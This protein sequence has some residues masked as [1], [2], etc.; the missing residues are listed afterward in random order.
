MNPQPIKGKLPILISLLILVL[1]GMWLLSRCSHTNERS[2]AN[3]FTRPTGDTIAVAI[4]MSPTSYFFS[5]DTAVGFD[6]EMLNAIA[7]AH[8]LNLIFQPFV[9]VDY[10]LDG[11]K[12]G[13]FDV[14]VATLPASSSMQND[15]LSTDEV[16]VDRQVLVKLKDNTTDSTETTPSQ[17]KLLKDTVWITDSSPYR[18]R[19]RNLSSELGDTIY[20]M[21]DPEYNAEQLVI[22]TAL[23][24]IKQAVVNETIAKRIAQDYPQIDISTPVSLSQF[25][26]WLL[27]QNKSDLRDSLNRWIEQFKQT[28]EY[29]KLTEKYFK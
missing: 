17:F 24:E 4:E 27:P 19:I 8:D 14:V 13:Q 15:F 23:G 26:P 22:L 18:E 12:K 11:L 29:S 7:K 6:Y 9:P 21:S 5:G 1:S 10:A 20:I 2:I 16:F 3:Q 28:P 25:Q